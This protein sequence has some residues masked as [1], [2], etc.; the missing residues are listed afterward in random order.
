MAGLD[1]QSHDDKVADLRDPAVRDELRH[2]V[3]NPN[4]D[5]DLGST[6]PPP[7]F[8][9]VSVDE[10]TRP[11][12]EKYL[13]RSIVDI[14]A[15]LGVDPADAMF[16]LALSEDLAMGFRWENFTPEWEASVTESIQHPAMIAGVSDG[17]P[18]S[19]ATT[20]PTGPATCFASGSTTA[21]CGAW[22]RRSAR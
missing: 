19:T 11:E 21:T 6:I 10:V 22:R 9:V 16:D 17:G 2:A 13:K 14:A 7:H 18:T 20:A 1:A 8:D 15:E 3:E 12:N 5:P 4:K